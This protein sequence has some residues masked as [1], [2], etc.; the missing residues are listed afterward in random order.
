MRDLLS[1]L[2]KS[3]GM[4]A[5]IGIT[6]GRISSVYSMN[7]PRLWG[8]SRGSQAVG[9]TIE[10]N[11]ILL[12]EEVPEW[13]LYETILHELLHTLPGC[14]NHGSKWR[15]Y[16][17]IVNRRLGYNIKPLSTYRD[18]GLAEPSI[19]HRGKVWAL[20]TY[21]VTVQFDHSCWWWNTYTVMAESYYEAEL[22]GKQMAEA[23]VWKFDVE[24]VEVV[25]AQ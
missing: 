13:A 18:K 16:A 10:I 25:M 23:E 20:K 24:V 11:S 4:L 2:E 22:L 3:K 12:N 7:M 9:Y 8:Y 21:K 17:A 1:Y 15:K 19:F 6:P 5:D 14:M